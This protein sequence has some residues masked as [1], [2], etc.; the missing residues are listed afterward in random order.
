[1]LL[2]ALVLFHIQQL[3]PTPRHRV[4]DFFKKKYP[5]R[6]KIEYPKND[7]RRLR[8]TSL[9]DSIVDIF[10][11]IHATH[12]KRSEFSSFGGTILQLHDNFIFSTL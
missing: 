1:M 6:V 12:F 4:D 10:V 3:N 9:E 5:T 8:H 2:T 7:A 11:C